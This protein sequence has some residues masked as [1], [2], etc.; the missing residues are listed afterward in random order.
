[1]VALSNLLQAAETSSKNRK[2]K[3]PLVPAQALRK[4]A[5]CYEIE[6]SGA[7]FDAIV[8]NDGIVTDIAS[9]YQLQH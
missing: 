1:M 4:V 8:D 7:I 2:K 9:L 6:N 3:I 5:F